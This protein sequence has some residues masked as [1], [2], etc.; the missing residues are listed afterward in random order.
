[1]KLKEVLEKTIHFFKEKKIEPPRLTAE[2]L[3]ADALKVQRVQLYLKYDTPLSQEEISLCREAVKRHALGEPVAYITGQKGF[4]GLD[5]LV[6]S[7]V[8]IPRPETEGLVEESLSWIKD[9]TFERLSIL[10]LGAGSGCLGFSILDQCLKSSIKNIT[11]VHL[12]SI[13]KSEQ[14]YNYLKRNCD[15]LKL[16]EYCTLKNEDVELFL[17][18]NEKFNIIVGNPPYIANN[19]PQ[20]DP[21]VDKYEPHQALYS[22]EHGMQDLKKWSQ[23]SVQQLTKPGL[24]LFEIGSQQGKAMKTFIEHLNS[25]SYVEILKDLSGLDRIIKAVQ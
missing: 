12:T 19:D 17:N 7:G 23:L 6:G 3:I 20:V 4:F 16:E 25:W 18:S 2:I 15:R 13:E 8:L 22:E 21:N 24:L 1:M 11:T 10:D 14:A 9:N 5:F